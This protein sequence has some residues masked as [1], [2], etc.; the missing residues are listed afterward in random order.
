MWKSGD[1]REEV[2]LLHLFAQIDTICQMAGD[3]RHVGLG[4]DFDGGYGVQSTPQE[5]DTIA[6]LQ[7]L[8]PLLLERGYSQEDTAA[9]LGENW[10]DLLRHSL[11]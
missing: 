2:S 10:L 9:I 1:L 11:P 5:I 7:K 3:A 6:D 8:A 4:T